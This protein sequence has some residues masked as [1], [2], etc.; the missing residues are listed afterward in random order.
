MP[1]EIRVSDRER[2]L[3]AKMS[4]RASV[5]DFRHMLDVLM[6]ETMRLSATTRG[7]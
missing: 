5:E 7:E 2:Y 6:E 3:S 1:L 4:G